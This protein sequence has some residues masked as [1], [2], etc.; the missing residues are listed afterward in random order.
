MEERVWRATIEEVSSW[1]TPLTFQPFG[2]GE[3]LLHP[4]FWKIVAHAVAQPNLF[5]AFF[6]NGT[7]WE[8]PDFA[9]ALET[10]VDRV[11]FSIDGVR[12]DF[13][14]H[15]RNGAKLARIEAAVHG[16]VAAREK[17]KRTTPRIHVN[18]VAHEEIADDAPAF[19]E[20]WRSVAD[21]ITV[22]RCRPPGVRV[23]LELPFDRVPCFN[24]DQVLVMTWD[25][26]V[27][28]CGEDPHGR[29]VSGHFPSRSLAEIWGGE[30]MARARRLHREGR[31]DEIPICGPCDAWCQQFNRVR[32]EPEFEIVEDPV[33]TAYRPRRAAPAD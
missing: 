7:L 29:Y 5:V 26:T 8:E 4:D 32:Q 6:T 31:W 24:L 13:I 15:F 22:N 18:M 19:V 25:G 20:R 11:T 12:P 3:P 2:M 1:G 16:M 17:A 10:G 27:G 21:E 33:Q 14:E 23:P 28:L 30:V 9:A